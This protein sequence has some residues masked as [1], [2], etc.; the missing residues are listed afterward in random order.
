MKFI[1][2]SYPYIIQ[3]YMSRTFDKT[4]TLEYFNLLLNTIKDVIKIT[5]INS[6]LK[7][8]NV[9]KKYDKNIS[10]IDQIK[11]IIL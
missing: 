7:N 5:T 3:K 10:S 1:N 9:L 8:V 2:L 4:I 11:N 6:T